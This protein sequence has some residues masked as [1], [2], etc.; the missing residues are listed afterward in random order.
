MSFYEFFMDFWEY[1]A[2]TN[3]IVK[4]VHVGCHVIWFLEEEK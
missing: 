3:L 4:A 1:P 2:N